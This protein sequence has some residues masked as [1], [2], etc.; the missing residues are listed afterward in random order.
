[1][2]GFN[3]A[4]LFIS[5]KIK[6]Q[7]V[8][9]LMF[10]SPQGGQGVTTTVLKTAQQ[11]KEMFGISP[12][13]VEMNQRRS[14]FCSMFSLDCK[15]SI[16]A[17]LSGRATVRESIQTTSSGIPV[18][19][20]NGETPGSNNGKIL[21]SSSVKD[22]LSE[23]QSYDIL[24]FDMPALDDQVTVF[25]M[26]EFVPNLVLVIEAGRTRREV[27]YQIRDDLERAN[28]AVIGT[29]LNGYKRYIPGW[30][31]NWLS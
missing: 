29:V 17:I 5:N 7:N 26:G 23:L 24:L 27:V 14:V 1:M 9:S 18:I 4:A 8:K 28:I 15:K 3:K 2:R 20:S 6:G 30:I 10:S 12:L 25:A 21:I 13:V 11:L 19:V 22:I 31:Y 16:E